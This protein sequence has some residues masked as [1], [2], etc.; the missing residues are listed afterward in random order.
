LKEMALYNAGELGQ[1]EAAARLE[2]ML[3]EEALAGLRD[4]PVYVDGR[5][6]AWEWRLVSTGF[7]KLDAVDHA[8]AHDLVGAQDIAWDVAGAQ[9]EFGLSP[10]EAAWLAAAAGANETAARL[11]APCYAAFQGGLFKL[12][13]DGPPAQARSAF[14]AAQLGRLTA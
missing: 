9:V 13:G 3:S 2:Q 11:L 1:A 5:L 10:E 8:V 12:V 6:H 7:C 4:R 14:Y